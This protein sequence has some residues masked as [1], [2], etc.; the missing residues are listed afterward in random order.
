M[1]IAWES[2]SSVGPGIDYKN[3]SLVPNP[4]DDEDPAW[5]KI[6]ENYGLNYND[7]YQSFDGDRD[8]N[9]QQKSRGYVFINNPRVDPFGK[10]YNTSIGVGV[11]VQLQLA[12]NTNQFGRTFEDRTHCFQIYEKPDYVGD[13]DIKLFSVQGR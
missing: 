1:I 8:G 12:I 9:P 7:I 6:W 5:V 2:E 13:N 10:L 3:N 11:R 4:F